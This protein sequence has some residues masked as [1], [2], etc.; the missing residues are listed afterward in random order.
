MKQPLN[1]QFFEMKKADKESKSRIEQHEV[2]SWLSFVNIHAKHFGILFGCQHK[3][4]LSYVMNI[5]RSLFRELLRKIE[6]SN[7]TKCG[8]KSIFTSV[9]IMYYITIQIPMQE[10][11]KL[12]FRFEFIKC[13][14]KMFSHCWSSSC[15]HSLNDTC[16][17]N[18][19][20]IYMIF[21]LDVVS[22]FSLFSNSFR[23]DNENGIE[24]RKETEK[25][26][27][28]PILKHNPSISVTRYCGRLSLKR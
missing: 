16:L 13:H 2:S 12:C 3:Q 18:Q 7:E 27:R 22:T 26:G 21:V 6:N 23:S 4:A 17:L 8:K 11:K 1:E 24:N 20:W 5:H 10:K 25:H 15:V 28:F 19:L 14:Y 9:H